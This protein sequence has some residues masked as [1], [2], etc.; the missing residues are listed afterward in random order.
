MVWYMDR[1]NALVL[2]VCL[3]VCL[4]VCSCRGKEKREVHNVCPTTY[5][6]QELDQLY[7]PLCRDRFFILQEL[8]DEFRNPTERDSSLWS[9]GWLIR[10]GSWSL[11]GGRRL[12]ASSPSG[13]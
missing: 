7:Q 10:P 3:S 12:T 11:L 9:N 6:P 13:M 2:G 8:H 1:A 5:L 4:V